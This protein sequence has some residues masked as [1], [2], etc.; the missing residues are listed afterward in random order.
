MVD[1]MCV[2]HFLNET[3]FCLR[4]STMHIKWFPPLI[5]IDWSLFVDIRKNVTFP[6]WIRVFINNCVTN[7]DACN[8]KALLRS[9]ICCMHFMPKHMKFIPSCLDCKMHRVSNGTLKLFYLLCRNLFIIYGEG[10]II[11]L[12]YM[13]NLHYI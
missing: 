7:I 6:F 12:V 1:I 9:N 3:I 5:L 4:F 11:N 8:Y 2:C 13:I 10:T